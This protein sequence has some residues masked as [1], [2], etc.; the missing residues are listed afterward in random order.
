MTVGSLFYVE[1]WPPVIILRRIMTP[2]RRI[3]RPNRRINTLGVCIQ[4]VGYRKITPIEKWPP[5]IIL[6]FLSYSPVQDRAGPW[7]TAMN[8]ACVLHIRTAL[9]HR[10]CNFYCFPLFSRLRAWDCNAQ[11]SAKICSRTVTGLEGPLP[12]RGATK[13]AQAPK[14]G[15]AVGGIPSCRSGPGGL[16]SCLKK[17]MQESIWVH[18]L[19]FACS[20]PPTVVCVFCRQSSIIRDAGEGWLKLHRSI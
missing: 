20:T 13:S 3:M 4:R 15:G 16:Q 18:L 19:P 14:R 1:K 8:A 5:Y 9:L 10:S 6:Y 12:G 7:N 11:G 2:S 17:W